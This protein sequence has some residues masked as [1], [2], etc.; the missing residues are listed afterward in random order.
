MFSVFKGIIIGI[1]ILLASFFIGCTTTSR[2]KPISVNNDDPTNLSCGVAF[3][4]PKTILELKITYSLSEKKTWQADA[5]GNFI[6]TDKEANLIAPKSIARVVLIDKPIEIKTKIIADSKMTF[7]FNPE[8]LSGFTKDTEIT[9]ELT[10]DGLIKTTNMVVADKSK[11]I[12]KNFTE[13]AFNIAKF[14]AVAGVDAVEITPIREAIVI[15]QLDPANLLFEKKDKLYVANYSALDEA[16]KIFVDLEIP[17]VVVKI[18]AGV[19]LAKISNIAST[20]L[21]IDNKKITQLN[22]FPYRIPGAAKIIISINDQVVYS[23]YHI[24][25]QAGGVAFVPINAKAFSNIT[26]GLNFSD[27][28]AV[29]TKYSSKGTSVGEALSLTTKETSAIMVER[30]K[31]LQISEL[32]NKIDIMKKEKELIEAELALQEAKRKKKAADSK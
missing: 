21:N 24:F 5:H 8:D 32:Q 19:D 28:S 1:L 18:I 16:K 12:A 23:D 6:K 14:A 13:T 11:E 17:E 27:D 20:D 7:I 15:E 22:G 2:I 31:D 30:I 10:K 26:Q 29:M 4:L 3:S 9:I 25:A